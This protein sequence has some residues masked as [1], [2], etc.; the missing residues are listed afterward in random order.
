MKTGTSMKARYFT[1]FAAA[2]LL[3]S[4]A[5]EALKESPEEYTGEKT[6]LTVGLPEEGKTYMGALEGNSRKIYWSNGDR[7]AVNGI[8]SVAL[9]YNILTI[10]NSLSNCSFDFCL[11]FD[12]IEPLIQQYL[13]PA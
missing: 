10:A 5:K 13:I 7:I 2:L 11:S 12:D 1:L 8:P 6:V 3:T 9:K 4:C